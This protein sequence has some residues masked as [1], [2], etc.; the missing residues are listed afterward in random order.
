MAEVRLGRRQV[1]DVELAA[2]DAVEETDQARGLVE[3]RIAFGRVDALGERAAVARL[4][5]GAAFTFVRPPVE[6]AELAATI[7]QRKCGAVLISS[8]PP[9]AA[10]SAATMARRLR[11]RFPDLKIVVGL[12]GG[13][14][15]RVRERLERLGVDTLITRAGEAEQALKGG[16]ESRDGDLRRASRQPA[17]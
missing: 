1:R 2:A 11:Q 7:E 6:P 3:R 10:S 15:E 12:W 16:L 8:V 17:G 5:P 4:L 14:R 9:K 13:E